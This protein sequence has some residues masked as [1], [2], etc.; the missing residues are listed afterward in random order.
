[1]LKRLALVIL[2]TVLIAP[3]PARTLDMTPAPH[4]NKLC[5]TNSDAARLATQLYLRGLLD[6]YTMSA[7]QMAAFLKVNAHEPDIDQALTRADKILNVCIPDTVDLAVVQK[8]FC[9]HMAAN[10]PQNNQAAA[11]QFVNAVSKTWPCS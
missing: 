6:G 3:K 2:M 5:R 7:A 10:P 4:L 9:A 1:M 8:A 11:E